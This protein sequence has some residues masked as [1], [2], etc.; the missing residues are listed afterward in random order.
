MTIFSGKTYRI[1]AH[2]SIDRFPWSVPE[3]EPDDTGGVTYG[4]GGA[5]AP[6]GLLLLLLLLLLGGGGSGAAAT[7]GADP[8]N[9]LDAAESV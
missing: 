5:V 3:D 6:Y 4:S 8:A 7:V 9:T 1:S 2:A